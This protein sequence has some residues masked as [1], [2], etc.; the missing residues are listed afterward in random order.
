MLFPI[1]QKM[2]CLH[3]KNQLVNAVQERDCCLFR[4]ESYRIHKC[5]VGQN[6][7]IFSVE[8]DFIVCCSYSESIMNWLPGYD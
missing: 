3:Y 8:A 7:E 5:T 6:A 4:E 1:S 2:H